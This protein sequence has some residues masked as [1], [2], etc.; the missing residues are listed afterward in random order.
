M[1]W[2]FEG[3]FDALPSEAGQDLLSEYWRSEATATRIGTMGY[4]TRTIKAGT[5]LEAEV[6]PIYGRS[7]EQAARKAKQNLTPERQSQLNTRRAKRRLILLMENNFRVDEDIFVTLTY[8]EEPTLQRCKKDVR[9]FFN[10]V[11]RQREKEKLPELKYLYAIGHDKD[12]RIHVHAVMNGGIPVKRLIKLWGKGIVNSYVLQTFGNGLQ[13]LANYLY[14]QNEKAKDNGERMYCHMWAGS[15]NLKK[16]KIHESDTKMP[17][18]KVKKCALGFGVIGKE[19]LERTYP[20]YVV[21]DWRVLFS[22]VVEGVYIRC[23]MRKKE[24]YH[25]K[26][27]T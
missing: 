18:R 6:Y 27:G 23:V 13:G 15:R 5:R 7:A 1:A 21:E 3:L 14:K 17:N 16:P 19:I 20:G 12:Q 24:A 22:D 2:E 11:K 9:N 25:D 8:A 10:R 4:R 26:K